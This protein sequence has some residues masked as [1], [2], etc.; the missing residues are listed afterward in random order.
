MTILWGDRGSDLLSEPTCSGN[1]G[2]QKSCIWVSSDWTVVISVHKYGGWFTDWKRD[3][4]GECSTCGDHILM[5]TP[6]SPRCCVC[7]LTAICPRCQV[8]LPGLY[9]GITEPQKE[10]QTIIRRLAISL[11]SI[12]Q[13]RTQPIGFL[14]MFV[15]PNYIHGRDG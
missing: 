14:A 7:Y 13:M 6:I 11:P 5:G 2:G 4:D 9:C 8:H 3:F 15:E 10:H 12:S 1:H